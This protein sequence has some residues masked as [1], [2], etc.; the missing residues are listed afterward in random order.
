LIN[1]HVLIIIIFIETTKVYSQRRR[2]T[3]VLH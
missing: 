1:K 2:L 3:D